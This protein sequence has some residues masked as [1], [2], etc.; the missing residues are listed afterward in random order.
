[1][2]PSFIAVAK[3]LIILFIMLFREAKYRLVVT[4]L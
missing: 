4:D 1:M 2:V 3:Y